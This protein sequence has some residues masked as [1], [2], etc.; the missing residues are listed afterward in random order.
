MPCR[1]ARKAAANTAFVVRAYYTRAER[2]QQMFH[3]KH[4]ERL[5]GGAT[6]APSRQPDAKSGELLVEERLV[7][8]T[9]TGQLVQMLVEG[10]EVTLR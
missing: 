3:V 5:L 2:H 10:R 1:H 8:P 9:L 7:F 4:A 6:R